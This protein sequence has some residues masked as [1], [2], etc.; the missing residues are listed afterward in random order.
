MTESEY[1]TEHLDNQIEWYSKKSSACQF[2]YKVL[3]IIEIIIA[4]TI[5][6]ITAINASFAFQNPWL[7]ILNGIIGAIIIIIEAICKM[8]KY[9]ENWIQ[10]RYVSELLKHEKH[11]FLTKT[12]PYDDEEYAFHLLVQRTERAISSENINWVGIN[13]DKPQRL[14]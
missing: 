13:E 5:P 7:N 11:L 12:E 10:Y 3:Q 6:I 8:N 2:R 4:A 14:Q 9:H 1:L